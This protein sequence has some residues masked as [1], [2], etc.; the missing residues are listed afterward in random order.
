MGEVG[1]RQTENYLTA[2][3]SMTSQECPGV[4]R[5]T[6][7]CPGGPGQARPPA[8][9]PAPAAPSRVPSRQQPGQALSRVPS[10]QQ[11]A[12]A[13]SSQLQHPLAPVAP[14]TSPRPTR[15][16]LGPQRG[17]TAPSQGL[18]SR[19]LH[20]GPVCLSHSALDGPKMVTRQLPSACL[21]PVARPVS[22]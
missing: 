19:L 11:P 22:L 12:S 8:P 10:C 16:P 6:Q 1:G 13:V 2:G 21:R 15:P 18:P 20:L 3:V 14:E 9:A 17:P 7:E 5:I 4:S